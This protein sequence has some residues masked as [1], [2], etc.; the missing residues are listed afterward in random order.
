MPSPSSDTA[1]LTVAAPA[2]LNLNLRVTGRRADGLHLLSGTMVLIDLQDTIT[3]SV[4][5]DGKIVRGWP[6]PQV[7]AEDDL[8]LRAARLL[9]QAAGCRL[10]VTIAI[11]KKIPIGG[12]LGGGSTDAAAVLAALNHLWQLN[13][14]YTRLVE[15]AAQLGADV[16]FFLYGEA[17]EI[18]GI[19]DTFIPANI[20][21][22]NYLLAFPPVAAQT[23]AVYRE[24]ARLVKTAN[25]DRI[26]P[27][28]HH[29]ANDL[30]RA[31]LNLYPH[32]KPVADILYETA[33]EARLSGSG[34]TVFAAFADQA[35][36]RRA[37]SRLP[38]HLSSAV[39]SAVARHP[40]RKLYPKL[41]PDN[42]GVAKW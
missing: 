3:L 36:A 14:S 42:W 35:R 7:A 27:S 19:G 25:I 22:N 1:R 6:H 18:G 12:G 5:Q 9:Q 37:Q 17:A 24:Y 2:K 34:S 10:G 13:C 40:L 41:Y 30:T 33:G 32:I 16:P 29:S 20:D 39:V 8:A 15:L 4:R 23:A 11:S 28:L 21:I 31:A 38:S 26:P